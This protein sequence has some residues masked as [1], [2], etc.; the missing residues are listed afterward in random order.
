VQTLHDAEET[1]LFLASQSLLKFTST[2][3]YILEYVTVHLNTIARN[4]MIRRQ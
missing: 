1:A 2:G 4:S 3:M